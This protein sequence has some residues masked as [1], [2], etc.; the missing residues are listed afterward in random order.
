MAG[1]RLLW[2]GTGPAALPAVGLDLAEAGSRRWPL[3]LGR[4]GAPGAAAALAQS[5]PSAAS[6]SVAAPPPASAASASNAR[7]A[8]V[9]L[10]PKEPGS[11]RFI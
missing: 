3:G 2:L 4:G 7:S 6:A 5:L 8:P 9:A 10:T 1:G 11:G